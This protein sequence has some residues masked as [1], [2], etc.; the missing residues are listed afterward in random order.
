MCIDSKCKCDRSL[1]RQK[2]RLIVKRYIQTFVIDIQETTTLMEDA[3]NDQIILS[4][5]TKLIRFC[6]TDD[7][8][9][10]LDTE[11]F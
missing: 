2:E 9:T 11:F 1:E 6:N 8:N 10:Y 3:N 4:I 7:N 5:A